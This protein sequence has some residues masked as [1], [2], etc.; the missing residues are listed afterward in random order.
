[1]HKGEEMRIAKKILLII[2]S[3]SLMAYA[4]GS[5]AGVWQDD[6]E[7]GK[8]GGWDEVSGTWEVIDGIY[9]QTDVVA[10]YQK[11]IHENETKQRLRLIRLSNMDQDR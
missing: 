11:S 7:D 9:E 4:A 2:V 1:M 5:Y 10:E 8:A 6:F 3:V